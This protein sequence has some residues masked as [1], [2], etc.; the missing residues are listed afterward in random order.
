MISMSYS[1]S[2][3]R[4]IIDRSK[5]ISPKWQRAE[6]SPCHDV[7]SK[8]LRGL[9][10]EARKVGAPSAPPS[11]R[12][13][14]TATTHRAP[15]GVVDAKDFLS[16][17][18]AVCRPGRCVR[19]PIGNEPHFRCG[20]HRRLRPWPVSLDQP[21]RQSTYGVNRIA[22]AQPS[23]MPVSDVGRI[24][25]LTRVTG[26]SMSPIVL[27]LALDTEFPAAYRIHRRA[28]TLTTTPS[29]P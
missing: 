23:S 1:G 11:E 2:R 25:R 4:S 24:R 26:I 10:P 27:L 9:R 15:G 20:V 21:S 29:M 16:K 7:F 13:R 18:R 14:G 17:T 3:P 6:M 12:R 19:R 22:Q 28:R 5:V 8:R